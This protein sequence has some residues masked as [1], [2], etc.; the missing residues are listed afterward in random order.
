MSWSS[1]ALK[2]GILPLKS[3][4]EMTEQDW[5]EFRNNLDPDIMGFDGIEGFP[6]EKMD[7]LE[8]PISRLSGNSNFIIK[9]NLT[10]RNFTNGKDVSRIKYIVIHYTANNGD[11]AWS[12]TNYFKS[13]YRG[14]S[15]HYFVDE[16]ST[17]WRCV[18]DEDIS[19]HCGGGIVNSDGASYYKKC[20]NSNSIGIEMC[21]RKYSNGT[22]YFKDQTIINC[23]LLVMLL[24]KKYNIPVENVIRHYDVT[25]KT[26]PAPF[27]NN[28]QNWNNFKKQLVNNKTEHYAKEYLDKLID[29]QIIN[30]QSAWIDFDSNVTKCLTIALLDKLTGGTWT[31]YRTDSKI[32]WAQPHVISLLGKNI[33][34]DYEQW[35]TT[36]N[37]NITK[38]LLLALVCNTLG[39][40]SDTYKNRISDHWA[41]NCLDTLCDKGV[42]QTPSSWTDF[43]SAVNKGQ[44]LALLY[45]AIY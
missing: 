26:C 24:M 44:T 25:G 9:D 37:D 31:S 17:I 35:V 20:V 27:V 12:N 21:S 30:N 16:N 2:C 19:W 7:V 5:F 29:K 8:E 39:G 10:T 1:E 41:R 43:N 28:I 33:I 45:K 36:L 40:I 32:H 42:I 38:G 13:V 34:T 23:A 22:Y 15:A 4:S 3:I 6:F 11:T 14:A 18:R